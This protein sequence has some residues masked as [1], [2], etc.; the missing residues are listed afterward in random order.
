MSTDKDILAAV[1]EELDTDP[2]VDADDIMVE[3]LNGAVSLNGTVPSQAQCTAAI[4]AA[5]R[6]AGVMGVDNMLA[7]ALPSGPAA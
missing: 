4:A 1:S 6:V 7:V 5:H 3:V 2:L